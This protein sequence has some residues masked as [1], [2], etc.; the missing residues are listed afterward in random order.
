MV[1]NSGTTEKKVD[2][3]EG[4]NSEEQNKGGVAVSG[5]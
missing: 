4:L 3:N 1:P 2:K 5:R